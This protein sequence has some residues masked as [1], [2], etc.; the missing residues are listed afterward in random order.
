MRVQPT[1]AHCACTLDAHLAG[2][3]NDSLLAHLPRNDGASNQC[4]E[5]MRIR[6]RKPKTND[7]ITELG[8]L[9]NTFLGRPLEK[10]ENLPRDTLFLQGTV[11]TCALRRTALAGPTQSIS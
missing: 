6:N 8:E 3:W 7:G 1:N 10:K 4:D 9:F 11:L 5:E 2:A